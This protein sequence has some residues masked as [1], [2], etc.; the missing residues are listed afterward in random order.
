M[1][2]LNEELY[3][4]ESDDGSYNDKFNESDEDED[5]ILNYFLIL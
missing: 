3:L 1:N 4:H 2:S 5:C